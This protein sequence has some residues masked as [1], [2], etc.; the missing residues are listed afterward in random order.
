MT[1]LRAAGITERIGRDF[2]LRHRLG[3]WLLLTG[4]GNIGFAIERVG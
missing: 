3:M 1:E 4:A 2:K